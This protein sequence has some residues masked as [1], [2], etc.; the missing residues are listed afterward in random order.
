MKFFLNRGL[1]LLLIIYLNFFKRNTYFV[2]F[3]ES[4]LYCALCYKSIGNLM[5]EA[6]EFTCKHFIC[7][8]CFPYILM[9]LISNNNHVI[10]WEFFQ[11]MNHLYHCPLCNKG[12][13]ACYLSMRSRSF[14]KMI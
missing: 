12:A 5:E 11:K 13:L 6:V 2:N 3:M 7:F 10:D 9:N 1:I 14:S 8:K 4:N